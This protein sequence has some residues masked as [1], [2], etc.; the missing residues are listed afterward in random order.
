MGDK[1]LVLRMDGAEQ[2]IVRGMNDI[3]QKY[4]LPC[5]LIEPIID[6]VHRQLIDGKLSEITAAKNREKQNST[7]EKAE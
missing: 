3:M 2:D 5:F 6:K 7:E 4:N 1:E